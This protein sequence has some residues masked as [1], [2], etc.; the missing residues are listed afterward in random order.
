M[1]KRGLFSLTAFPIRRNLSVLA[2]VGEEIGAVSVH[3]AVLKVAFVALA[4]LPLESTVAVGFALDPT[5]LEGES[6]QGV[7]LLEIEDSFY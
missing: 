7:E 4:V 5:A 2:V 6:S 1:M 3:I